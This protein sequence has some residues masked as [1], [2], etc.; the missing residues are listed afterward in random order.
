MELQ[1][2]YT[3]W[4]REAEILAG[5]PGDIR[6]RAVI[7]HGIFEDSGRNHGFA[8]IATHGALWAYNFFETTGT[9][10]KLISYRYFYNGREMKYRHGLL[11]GFSEGFKI[12]N[13]SVFIDTYSNYYFTK[14]LDD[15]CVAEKMFRPELLE[16]LSRIHRA[17]KEKKLL[18]ASVR[19]RLFQTTL[20]WEQE[21]TVAPAVKKA[22]SKFDCPILKALVLK[23]FVRFSYF[24]PRKIF[25]FRNFSETSERIR[26]AHECFDV[27]ES[28]GWTKVF[29]ALK[30]YEVLDREFFSSPFEFTQRLK[31]RLLSKT[32]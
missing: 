2:R 28:V 11:N 6:Q 3:N 14:E 22:V 10:G 21:T 15:P 12:A 5:K 16:A 23:P 29:E 26:R 7:L 25:W 30:K 19:R 32:V 1:D 27:A 17:A 24:P 8:E 13:R 31:A 20:Q 18:D 4:R 9:L